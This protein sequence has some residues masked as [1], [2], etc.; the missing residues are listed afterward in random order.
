MSMKVP[1]WAHLHQAVKCGSFLSAN[2]ADNLSQTLLAPMKPSPGGPGLSP[3]GA[4]RCRDPT[5][6]QE[7]GCVFVS[8]SQRL[9]SFKECSP[10]T[11]AA[12][13]PWTLRTT[14]YLGGPPPC[15]VSLWIPR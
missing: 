7:R 4:A 6:S 10:L 5:P 13:F 9:G 8:R 15:L 14:L 3:A 2:T 11:V 1:V 12:T